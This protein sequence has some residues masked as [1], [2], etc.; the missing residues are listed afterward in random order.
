MDWQSDH[1][2]WLVRLH[3]FVGRYQHSSPKK[4]AVFSSKYTYA[5]T[6][7]RCGFLTTLISPGFTLN[8]CAVTVFLSL[9]H[10][11][12]FMQNFLLDRVIH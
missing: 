10:T 7:D 1:G 12:N 2:I 9:T 11:Q 6:A 3:G 8:P 4:E 5:S